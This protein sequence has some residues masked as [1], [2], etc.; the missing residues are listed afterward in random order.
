MTINPYLIST[1]IPYFN[2]RF[3]L[4]IEAVESVLSQSYSN[5]E[6]I[7]INDGSTLQNKN[8]LE[9]YIDKINDKRISIIHLDK[10]HGPSFARNKG[11]ETSKGGIITLLDSDDILLP[12]YYEKLIDRFSKNQDLGI[13]VVNCL[14]YT[15]LGNIKKISTNKPFSNLLDEIETQE[16]LLEIFKY[17]IENLFPIVTFAGLSR[18]FQNS[19]RELCFCNENL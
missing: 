18:N 2:T 19:V 17:K 11:I 10:N 14:F 12:W 6:A 15:R 3:D 8:L 1:I 4:F 5:W 7:I 13:I 9:E 16:T